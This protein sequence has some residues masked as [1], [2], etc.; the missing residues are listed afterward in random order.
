MLQPSQQLAV[1]ALE[2]VTSFLDARSRGQTLV[3]RLVEYVAT[4]TRLGRLRPGQR[5]PS[6]RRLAERAHVS[7]STA[8]A[9]CE[10]L[11]VLGHAEARRGSGY[12]VRPG[13]GPEPGPSL[14][15]L[16]SRTIDSAWLARSLRDVQ[17]M[18][19]RPGTGSFPADWIDEG[20]TEAA[21]RSVGRQSMRAMS[22]YGDPLGWAALRAQLRVKLAEIHVDAPARQIVTTS[23]ATHG[24]EIVIAGLLEAGDAVL[25]DDPG[26]FVMFEKL[27]ARR[28]RMLAV[29]WN[30]DGP[31]LAQVEALARLYRPRLMITQTACHNPTGGTITPA[32]A[33]QLLK[34]AEAFDFM[35]L[36]NDVW[37]DL[38]DSRT[39]RLATL[40]QLRRVVYLGSFSKTLQAGLRVGYL[41]AP[42]AMA[43]ALVDGKL[44]LSLTTSELNERVVQHILGSGRY[45]RHIGS[46]KSKLNRA[47]DIALPALERIGVEL[48]PWPADGLFAWVDTGLDTQVVAERAAQSGVVLAPG[49]LFSPV[50]A[51]S[52]SMRLNIAACASAATCTAL[53]RLIEAG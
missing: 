43:E 14:R 45:R 1:D 2:G 5:L 29:P 51:A 12:F 10:Q 22:A 28:V 42:P 53:Q 16:A 17:P 15:T 35:I 31:D 11:V 6:V 44:R 38:A 37:G 30:A 19:S 33:H 32:V 7:L 39:T 18:A 48:G 9:A 24:M 34:L 46:L 47:R 8:A 21:L 40:D 23:G 4:Q 25:V 41:A 20:L 52:T 3:D 49:T 27:R 13:C 50:L 36:E 26:W